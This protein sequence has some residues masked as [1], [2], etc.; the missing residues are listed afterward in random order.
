MKEEY[1]NKLD[2]SY[3]SMDDLENQEL[4]KLIENGTNNRRKNKRL[5]S[6][7]KEHLKYFQTFNSVTILI[8]ITCFLFTSVHRFTN[9]QN[10]KEEINDMLAFKKGIISS[11][12]VCD[13]LFIIFV[14]SIILIK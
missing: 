9:N 8:M 12:V 14:A 1:V 10:M 13:Y 4:F 2:V 3:D 5:N 11:N 6:Y 7:K